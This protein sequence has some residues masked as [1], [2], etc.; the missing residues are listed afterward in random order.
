MSQSVAEQ[1]QKAQLPEALELPL[2]DSQL[3]ALSRVMI[4]L[5]RQIPLRSLKVDSDIDDSNCACE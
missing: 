1:R 3:H 5:D 2:F 4:L